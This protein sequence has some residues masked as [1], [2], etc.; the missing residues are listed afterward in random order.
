MLGELQAMLLRY[1]VD[2]CVGSVSIY[3]LYVIAI[4]GFSQC[5]VCMASNRLRHAEP[6]QYFRGLAFVV[7][8]SS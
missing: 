8:P 2:S 1:K 3:H 7:P 4:L 5:V 6:S